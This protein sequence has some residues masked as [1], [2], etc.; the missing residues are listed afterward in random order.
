M[1]KLS[2][3]NRHVSALLMLC[4]LAPAATTVR[5]QDT[6]GILV[7]G[8][9]EDFVIL[10]SLLTGQT[11]SVAVGDKV[12]NMFSY[13]NSGDM[14]AAADV[15]VFGFLD[16]DGNYG[17]SLHGSFLDLPGDELGSS[18][19]LA[20]DVNVS[21][22]GLE[23]GNRISDAHLELSGPGLDRSS[24]SVVRVDESFNSASETLEVYAST[25]DD[26]APDQ[27]NDEVVFSQ[28]YPS[29][30]AT[31]VVFALAEEDASQP[32]R[33]TAIDFSFSQVVVPEPASAVLMLLGFATTIFGRVRRG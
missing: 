15:N 32:A 30:R 2:K 33:T 23:L 24:Q 13:S 28:T 3:L 7:P 25:L 6:D 22:A 19:T 12:F 29:L 5:A 4:V 21:D 26:P 27:L 20:F 11:P 18:A 1:T 31:F 14:P 8:D 10:S 16:Q 9:S 17:L